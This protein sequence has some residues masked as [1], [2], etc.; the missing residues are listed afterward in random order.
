MPEVECADCGRVHTNTPQFE[1]DGMPW[2]VWCMHAKGQL[3]QAQLDLIC[4][5]SQT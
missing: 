2:C 1:F 5:E 3:T 4:S